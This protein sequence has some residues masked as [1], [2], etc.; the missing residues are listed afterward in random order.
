MED[1]II[2]AAKRYL[3]L[4]NKVNDP[5]HLIVEDI[6]FVYGWDADD[7]DE[8]ILCGV[9][10]D[11]GELPTEDI[12]RTLYEQA[13]MKVAEEIEDWKPCEIRLDNLSL[14]VFGEDKALLRHHINCFDTEEEE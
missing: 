5:E 6:P 10:W 12:P 8:F 13:L 1:R 3:T 14:A 2:K 9:Q 7:E 4:A 11:F